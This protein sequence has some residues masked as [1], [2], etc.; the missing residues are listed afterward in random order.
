[1]IIIAEGLDCACLIG[2]GFVSASQCCECDTER[3]VI[4]CATGG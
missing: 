2:L 4:T 1:M 3:Y